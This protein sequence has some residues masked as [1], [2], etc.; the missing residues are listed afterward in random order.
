MTVDS[1]Q[2]SLEGQVDN[3]LA[4]NQFD[5]R[6]TLEREYRTSKWSKRPSKSRM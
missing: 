4:Y 1:V 2:S 5:V 6:V 3:V